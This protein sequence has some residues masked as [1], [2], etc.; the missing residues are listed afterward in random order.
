MINLKV[1]ELRE[2]IGT[3]KAGDYVTLSGVI[4]T[5][6]DAAHKRICELLSKGEELPFSLKDSVIYY[7]GPTPAKPGQIIGSCGPTTASRMDAFAPTLLDNGLCA[8]VGKG[9]RNQNVIDAIV[10]NGAIY[11]CAIGGAGAI[12]SK[13]VKK[14]D[15]IAFPELGCEA[16][17]RLEVE[18]MPLIVGI[19]TTGKSAIK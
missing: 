19:D 1:N 10:R 5:A 8:M 16:V 9:K 2:K 15:I 14:C 6:R 12:A 17:R 4:Y 7:A 3:L 11:F 18:E 13:C